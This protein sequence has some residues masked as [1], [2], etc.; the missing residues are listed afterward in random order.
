MYRHSLHLVVD[1]LCGWTW[2]AVPLM[3]AVQNIPGLTIHI[4]GGG[5]ITDHQRRHIS[6]QWRDFALQN[7]ECIAALTGQPFG[8]RY[9]NQL[10]RDET[11]MLDSTP[12]TAALLAGQQMGLSGVD[13][14]AA[15]QQAW[16]RDGR[17]ITDRKVLLTLAEG[18]GLSGEA[19]AAAL[20]SLSATQTAEHIRQSRLLLQQIQGQGFPSAALIADNRAIPLP[21]SRY[22][23]KP[24]G[25]SDA[26]I[27]QLND[28]EGQET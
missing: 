11:V 17:N 1:P 12:P 22:Y 18:L 7:D 8:E 28:A 23:G 20:D 2:G 4:H 19:F 14:L 10:L 24:Q 25:W 5:M 13:M 21:L 3:Q 6:P 16:Y 9:A 26:L 27:E 15:L